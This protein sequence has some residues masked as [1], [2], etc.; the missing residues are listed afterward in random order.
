MP[1][2]RVWREHRHIGWP[3]L[4][5]FWGVPNLQVINREAHTAK[6]ASEA[7]Y[8]GRIRGAAEAVIPPEHS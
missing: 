6:C 5:G 2:F 1:L 8:R 3:A 4:L 7:S